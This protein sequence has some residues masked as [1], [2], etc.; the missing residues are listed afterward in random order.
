MIFFFDFLLSL[1]KITYLCTHNNILIGMMRDVNRLKMVLAKTKR[2]NG[3]VAEYL[4]RDETIVSKRCT[5]AR[6]PSLVT[7]FKIAECLRV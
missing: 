2:T 3:W 7:L 4:G 5:S 6:K 1:E